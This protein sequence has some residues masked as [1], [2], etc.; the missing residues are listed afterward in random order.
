MR[1]LAKRKFLQAGAFFFV[2]TFCTL[3]ELLFLGFHITFPS[4]S[5]TRLD[6]FCITVITVFALVLIILKLFPL[7]KKLVL[8]GFTLAEGAFLDDRQEKGASL[9]EEEKV[10][11]S[12]AIEISSNYQKH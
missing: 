4:A 6:Y 2:I 10:I 9:S 3:A 12:Q 7:A 11:L 1:T 5:L 8:Q